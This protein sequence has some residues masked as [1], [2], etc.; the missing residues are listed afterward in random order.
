MNITTQSFEPCVELNYKI[1]FHDVGIGRACVSKIAMDKN[2]VDSSCGKGYRT[3][4]K[5]LRFRPGLLSQTQRL[6]H[7]M[8][9]SLVLSEMENFKYNR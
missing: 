2:H 7:V 3:R 1:N 5:W 9:R 8:S 6:A 4:Y